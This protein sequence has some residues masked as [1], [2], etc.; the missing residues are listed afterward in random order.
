MDNEEL[1]DEEYEPEV[2]ELEGEKY[3][4]IDAICYNDNNYVAIIPYSEEEPEDDEETVDFT[5]L[6][7]I[8]G[9]EEEGDTL[10]TVDDDALYEEIG[11]AFIEHINSMFEECDCDDEDCHCKD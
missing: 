10:K 4:V 8:E 2:I 3:E 5:I 11:N 7:V 6:E 9:T 1:L